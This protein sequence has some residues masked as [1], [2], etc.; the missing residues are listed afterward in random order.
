MTFS[1]ANNDL[2]SSQVID[3]F[4][5]ALNNISVTDRSV[6]VRTPLYYDR[7]SKTLRGMGYRLNDAGLNS[8][9]SG[10]VAWPSVFNN[11]VGNVLPLVA[12]LFETENNKFLQV[13]VEATG[14]INAF[15]L[16]KSIP[17][18]FAY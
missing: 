17:R 6:A 3:S 16:F 4:R 14:G 1:S 10:N 8:G 11:A 5:C 12:E 15:Q 2:V 7:L 18:T 9:I 13:N